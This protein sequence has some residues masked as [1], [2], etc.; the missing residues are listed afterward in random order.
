MKHNISTKGFILLV[1]FFID[2][3]GDRQILADEFEVGHSTIT[4]WANGI[5]IPHPRIQI[6]ISSFIIDTINK[7]EIM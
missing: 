2:N 7:A 6:S 5:S 4:R 3:G 1:K